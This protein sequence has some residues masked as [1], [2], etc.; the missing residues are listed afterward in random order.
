MSELRVYLPVNLHW[1]F[2]HNFELNQY[3]A[4]GLKQKK[5]FFF[6]FIGYTDSYIDIP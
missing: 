1:T 2:G 6:V 3:Q 5:K 4:F